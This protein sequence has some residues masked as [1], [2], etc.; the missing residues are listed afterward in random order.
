MSG[1]TGTSTTIITRFAPS[2]TGHMHMGNARTALFSLLFARKHA[3]NFIVRSEDTDGER[4]AEEYLQSLLRDLQRL[5]YVWQTGPDR[6]PQM[7]QS[8]RMP[9][10]TE[11]YNRLQQAS[12]VYPCYCS[13]QELKLTRRAQLSAGQ[14]P[15][16]PGTCA[17]LTVEQQQARE[18]KGLKP[19]LRFRVPKDRKIEFNDLVRGP[20]Q[21]NSNDIGDF[22]IRRADG[23]PAFFFTNAVD[24]ALMG[25]THV[26]RGEDHL[27]NTPRQILLLEALGLRI[28]AY[29]HISLILGNDGTPLSKRNGSKSIGDLLAEGY[30]PI[31]LNNYMARLGHAY[32]DNSLMSLDG[33]AQ[34]FELDRL[35]KSPARFDPE[36]LRH[37]QKEAVLQASADEIQT[38]LSAGLDINR[39]PQK[40]RADFLRIAQENC[41][42]PPEAA[43]LAELLYAE[44]LEYDSAAV[45]VI[46]SAGPGYYS[47][48]VKAVQDKGNYAAMIETIKADTQVKGKA[49]F[50]PFRV[51]LTGQLHGP[52]LDKLMLLMDKSVIINRFQTALNMNSSS[53]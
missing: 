37:W 17:Q 14:P 28:P 11:H 23:T 49:L 5:G 27:T 15:R 22:I 18:A 32:A 16:Y 42:L 25:V 46:R 1:K 53:V 7:R 30:L 6:D 45:E 52:E 44:K 40:H 13:E 47:S 2:P 26:L 34:A 39:I 41:A 33:L 21:F 19:T 31:A 3:G 8:N 12:L 24:D 51:A 9:I 36:Q 48:A 20:Q 10:Y 38:W 29:G 50:M 43:A 4:S 35:G